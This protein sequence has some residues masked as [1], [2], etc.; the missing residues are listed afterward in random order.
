MG[1]IP[2]SDL[3]AE[4]LAEWESVA[5]SPDL[6]AADCELVRA[7]CSTVVELR[8]AEAWC[9][10]NGTV[11]TLRDDKGNVRSQVQAPKY[12]Q[13]RGLRADLVKLAGE[14]GFSPRARGGV[15]VE[16]GP[17]V[18]SGLLRLLGGGESKGA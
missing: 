16:D 8:A 7:W 15:S 9:A 4:A 18:P 17:E 11:L 10:E 3:S 13:V 5:S 12:V 6:L 2:P 14:L 1:L